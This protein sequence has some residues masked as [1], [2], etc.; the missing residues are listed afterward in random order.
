MR[1]IIEGQDYGDII[2]CV[3]RAG[4]GDLRDLKRHSGVTAK[5]IRDAINWSIQQLPKTKAEAKKFDSL[6]L[7]ENDVFLDNMIGAI[8]LAK[9]K[10]GEV[11]FRIEDAERM[12]FDS[13][14][15]DFNDEMQQTKAADAAPKEGPD[16]EAEATAKSS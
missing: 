1:I 4:L 16:P 14:H 5:S 10:A 13:F 8:F 6:D 15:F 3:G 9:R 12:P 7:L 11:D 2:D